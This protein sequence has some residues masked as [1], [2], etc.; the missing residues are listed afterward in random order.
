MSS[1]L[2]KLTVTLDSKLMPKSALATGSSP[3]LLHA[4]SKVAPVATLFYSGLL[5]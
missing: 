4:G 3:E 5:G 2:V 1:L